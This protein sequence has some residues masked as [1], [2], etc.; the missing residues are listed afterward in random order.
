MRRAAFIMVAAL[1]AL[2]AAPAGAQA[3]E[4]FNPLDVDVVKAIQCELDPRTYNG[5]ALTLDSDEDG[6][7]ARGWT[8][9]ESGNIMLS[10]Y[11]LPQPITVAGHSTSTIVFSSSAVMAVLDADPRDLAKAE[12]IDSVYG[13]AAKF[14]GE[15]EISK[16][17]ETVE[18]MTIVATVK[19]TLSNV[20]SHPGKALLG[21]VYSV[22]IKE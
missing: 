2:G 13:D 6:Y 8:K 10:Q 7:K 19:R 20:T 16:Q 5:F 17:T 12:A 15:R 14:L 11:R 3:D 18:G 4:D 22:E 21:C 9:Q 1:A